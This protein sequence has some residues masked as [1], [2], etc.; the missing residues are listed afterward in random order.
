VSGGARPGGIVGVVAVVALAYILLNTLRA[1][2]P[3]SQGLAP[4]SRLPPFAAPLATSPLEGDVNVAR[5]AGQGSAGRRAACAVRGPDIVNSC[6][7]AARGPVVLA[8]VATRGARC[9]GELDTLDRVRR[10]HPDVQV[11]AI[12][13]R[14][15]RDALR[16]LIRERRWSFPVAYDRDGVLANLYGVA[17]CPHL[18]FALRG[19]RV[20]SSVLGEQD[21][22]ALERRFADLERAART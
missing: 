19:G 10:S 6:Q 17:V 4:G 22:A 12:A 21:A 20:Q 16:R 18:T 8:F 2:G 14:G 5:R 13:I 7:L 1:D 9:T 3:G 11:V 15:D